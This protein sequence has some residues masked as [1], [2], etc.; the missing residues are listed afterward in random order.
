MSDEAFGDE[1]YQP[2][3]SDDRDNPDDLDL[4][5]ALDE[6][7]LDETLDEG[8]SPPEKPLAVTKH[9]TTAGEQREGA[10]LDQR[11][12]QEEPDVGAPDGNGIGDL[13]GGDGE[14]LDDQVGEVRAGRL[15][16]ADEGVPRR[17]EDVVARD[18]GVDGGAAAAEE[19]AVHIV[20]DEEAG[21]AGPLPD[22]GRVPPAGPGAA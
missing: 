9:G 11:L 6:K 3:D 16:G 12:A 13:P 14:P 7:N 15:V 10:S 4:E 18:V 19:A 17:N 20:P 22:K 2:V 5:N 1:V 21:E 8:Y